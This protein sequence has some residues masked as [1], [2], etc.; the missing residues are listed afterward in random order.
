MSKWQGGPESQKPACANCRFFGGNTGR[1]N[2]CCQRRAPTKDGFPLTMPQD[3]CGEWE[4][5]KYDSI[6]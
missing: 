6:S 2:Y 4:K 1:M 3:W 5:E